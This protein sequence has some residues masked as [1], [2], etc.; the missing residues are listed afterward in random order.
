VQ[1]ENRCAHERFVRFAVLKDGW[2]LLQARFDFYKSH[3][4]EKTGSGYG[5]IEDPGV[6]EGGKELCIFRRRH[7]VIHALSQ[8]LEIRPSAALCPQ[9]PARKQRIEQAAEKAA[10]LRDPVKGGRA[11]DAVE[12]L[13]ERQILQ[14]A[15]GK[16]NSRAELRRQVIASSDEHVL[17]NVNSHNPATRQSF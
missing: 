13:P 17:R 7:Q 2:R 9:P 6:A 11:E 10:L 8:A 3:L 14:V 12:G 15:G 4:P 1:A 5:I 16:V